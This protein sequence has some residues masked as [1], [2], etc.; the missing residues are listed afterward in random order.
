LAL[1]LENTENASGA[2][3]GDQVVS[4]PPEAGNMKDANVILAAIEA[5]DSKVSVLRVIDGNA[6]RINEGIWLLG[7]RRAFTVVSQRDRLLQNSES[8]GVK[9]TEVHQ[10][11]GA[12]Q[13]GWRAKKKP[14]SKR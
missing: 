5:G 14:P 13:A 11:W 2:W 12:F 3:R 1:P 7:P 4:E 9:G 10:S 8:Q 6:A